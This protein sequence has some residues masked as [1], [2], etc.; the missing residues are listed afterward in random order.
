MYDRDYY[1]DVLF[2]H[3]GRLHV[4]VE[5]ACYKRDVIYMYIWLTTKQL[6]HITFKNGT[7]LPVPYSKNQSLASRLASSSFVT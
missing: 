3:V 2:L 1:G 4:P 6:T 7:S 5:L